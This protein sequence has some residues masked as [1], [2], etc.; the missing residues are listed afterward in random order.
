MTVLSPHLVVAVVLALVGAAPTHGQDAGLPRH[1]LTRT[2]E[3]PV[4]DGV[5]DDAVWANA[6]PIED[7]RQ[8]EPVE[9]G[10]PSE[11]TE[12]R[13]LFDDDALYVAMR[14][15]DS[16]PAGVV[17]RV[18]KRDA[19]FGPDDFV[20]IVVDPFFDRRNG[21]YFEMSATGAIGDAA[22]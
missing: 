17:A 1:Q 18:M 14:C 13:L 8:T 21:Y 16:D 10:V 6:Q 11:R 20:A 19:G 7:F 2:D 4:I 22:V 9:G 3:P 12:L 15:Y 5:L